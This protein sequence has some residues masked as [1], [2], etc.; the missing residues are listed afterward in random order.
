MGDD[1]RHLLPLGI[2]L[3]AG[4]GRIVGFLL[5]D[6]YPHGCLTVHHRAA[7]YQSIVHPLFRADGYLQHTSVLHGLQAQGQSGQHLVHVRDMPDLRHPQHGPHRPVAA[8]HLPG[9]QH[10]EDTGPGQTL[11]SRV[12]SLVGTAH[13]ALLRD[14]IP[15]LVEQ[16]IEHPVLQEGR[17]FRKMKGQVPVL[18]RSQQII[19]L[20]KVACIDGYH[21]VDQEEYA[22]HSPAGTPVQARKQEPHCR[23]CREHQQHERYYEM[24]V[25]HGAEELESVFAELIVQ[26]LTG[27]AELLGHSRHIAVIAA[28]GLPDHLALHLV[29]SHHLAGRNRRRRYG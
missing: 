4:L 2:L 21:P 7:L 6:I 19:E 24:P 11:H 3:R 25:T 8:P 5:E 10:T 12:E 20:P 16:D 29:Q 27:D 23:P 14:K 15:D 26:S 9:R 28:Q 13:T 18:K 1:A 17:V 22:E